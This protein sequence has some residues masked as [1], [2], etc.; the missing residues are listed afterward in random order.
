MSTSLQI[1]KEEPAAGGDSS[2]V[3]R[4]YK[5]FVRRDILF[6]VPVKLLPA[7]SGLLSIIILSRNLTPA[8][9]GTYSVVIITNLLA[10]Q[11][12]GGWLTSAVLYLY[13]D[14]SGQKRD[15]QTL[16]LQIQA[17]IVIPAAATVFLLL[18]YFTHAIDIAIIGIIA[19]ILYVFQCLIQTLLQCSREVPTQI[20]AVVVQCVTQVSILWI[21][22]QRWTGKE[23][24]ALTAIAMGYAA[25]I[26]CMIAIGKIPVGLRRP[27][28]RIT[29][30]DVLR[31]LSTYGTPMCVWFFASQFISVGDRLILKKVG[32]SDVL[33]QYASFKDL[34]VGSAGLMAMPLLLASHPIIM[35]MW[36]DGSKRTEIE[37]IIVTNAKLVTLFFAPLLAFLYVSGPEFIELV[38]GPR[39][40]PSRAIMLIVVVSVYVNCLSVY[41]QKGLE[42]TGNTI[43]MAKL[44]SMTA[45]G[46]LV[47]NVVF[48]R[49]YGVT[50][51]ATICLCGS[52]MYLL[53][54]RAWGS[55]HLRTHMPLKF[56]AFVGGWIALVSLLA[57]YL[58]YRVQIDPPLLP[59]YGGCFVFVAWVVFVALC[60][61]RF[62]GCLPTR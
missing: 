48:A 59:Y 20:Y 57:Q 19:L 23:L 44:I 47:A 28:D 53:M 22:V 33:G 35:A 40:A 30:I 34:M 16:T 6:Y 11:V 49:A 41:A 43:L 13:P 5:R 1:G 38:L 45:T 42:V 12:A 7:L 4:N 58:F 8:Q 27:F 15:F 9:Y 50:A 37:E 54:V 26:L 62:F 56:L 61:Q 2:S 55:R 32:S 10:A 51:A 46:C 39:Y 29:S 24:A 18:V 31:K 3:S 52:A 17:A 36:K 14:Y 21:L 25:S 60:R